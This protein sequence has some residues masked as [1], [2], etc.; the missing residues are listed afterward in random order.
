MIYGGLWFKVSDVNCSSQATQNRYPGQIWG[1]FIICMT[2]VSCSSSQN[3]FF[4]QINA[5][6]RQG[7]TWQKL[8]R[9]RPAKPDAPSI[10]AI[11]SDGRK[12]VCYKLMPP[13]NGTA[14]SV[15]ATNS[16]T[17]IPATSFSTTPT[18]DTTPEE[19]SG[20]SGIIWNFS[21]F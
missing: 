5:L 19:N 7:Y 9:C 2:L 13:H 18:P 17:T 21:N 12:L 6:L 1:L 10:P 15:P 4:S 20:A 3:A 8:E 14:A 16:A 11:G